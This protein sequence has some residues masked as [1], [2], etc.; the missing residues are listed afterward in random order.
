M[1]DAPQSHLL[2]TIGPIP[3]KCQMPRQRYPMGHTCFREITLRAKCNMSTSKETSRH[4]FQEICFFFCSCNYQLYLRA[5]KKVLPSQSPTNIIRGNTFCR[6]PASSKKEFSKISK[7]S[8]VPGV[9]G[10]TW[11]F[12]VGF[13][14]IFVCLSCHRT[15]SITLELD[16]SRSRVQQK[17]K[18]QP[19]LS[20]IFIPL[21]HLHLLH[22]LH[23]LFCSSFSFFPAIRNTG[24]RKQV[25]PVSIGHKEEEENNPDA[26]RVI[27]SSQSTG[28]V[29][30]SASI[31]DRT[32]LWFSARSCH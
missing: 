13:T 14:F 3:Q 2:S 24:R 23:V 22:L 11:T 4:S 15:L 20:F 1:S 17:K 5:K 28:F 31:R 12:S 25:D 8:S 32:N 21:V 16:R 29:F 19:W 18:Q 7:N 26:I 9:C 27:I 6:F 30:Y 10:S